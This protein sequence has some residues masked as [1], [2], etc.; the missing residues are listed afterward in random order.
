MKERNLRTLGFHGRF[1][2]ISYSYVTSNWN[3]PKT[4]MQ[5]SSAG[6]QSCALSLDV[7]VFIHV[8]KS[9]CIVNTI[10]DFEHLPE[11]PLP[12]SER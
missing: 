7:A 8:S 4:Q 1:N 11:F 10:L 12:Q 6:S 5:P 3:S 9:E 2:P